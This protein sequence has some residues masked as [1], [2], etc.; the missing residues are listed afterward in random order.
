M[1]VLII[2]KSAHVLFLLKS[3]GVV[4]VLEVGDDCFQVIVEY[5]NVLEAASLL[6]FSKRFPNFGEGGVL[7]AKRYS[8]QALIAQGAQ[9]P[10]VLAAPVCLL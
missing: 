2:K 3:L 8:S 7:V 4:R 10:E 5:L 1:D 6:H 9:S